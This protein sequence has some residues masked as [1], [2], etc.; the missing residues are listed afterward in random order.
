MLICLVCVVRYISDALVGF[1]VVHLW[2]YQWSIG[3]YVYWWICPLEG[4]FIGVFF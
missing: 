2:A 3:E 1:L 4:F